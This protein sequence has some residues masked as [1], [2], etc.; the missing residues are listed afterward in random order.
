MQI[1]RT[2]GEKG[3]IVVPKDIRNYIGIRPGSEI[4]F[5]VKDGNVI[6]KSSIDPEKF[7]EDFCNIPKNLRKDIDSKQI[8]KMLDEQYEERFNIR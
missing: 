6:I 7:V 5:E 1:K 2:V 3:Q 4:V 8:K